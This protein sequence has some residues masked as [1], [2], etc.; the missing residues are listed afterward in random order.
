MKWESSFSLI[1]LLI[2]IS[3]TFFFVG[4]SLV[5]YNN[6]TA[7]KELDK[8]A[9]RVFDFI[10]LV[11]ENAISNKGAVEYCSLISNNVDKFNGWDLSI[12]PATKSFKAFRVCNDLKETTP[13]MSTIVSIDILSPATGKDILFKSSK[14]SLSSDE[15]IILKSVK[16]N[17]CIVIVANKSGVITISKQA[18]C[19]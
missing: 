15:T 5:Y 16:L 7:K 6:F 14:G 13:S 9:R 3:I 11:R 10:N 12:N 4:M 18:Q 1:E 17:K 8:E 2:V 19:P